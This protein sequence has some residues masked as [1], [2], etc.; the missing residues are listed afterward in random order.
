MTQRMPPHRWRRATGVLKLLKQRNLVQSA[1]LDQARL[2]D[3]KHLAHY[4]L[5]GV[6]GVSSMCMSVVKGVEVCAVV[7][8]EISGH[9]ASILANANKDEV[10]QTTSHPVPQQAIYNVGT[11]PSHNVHPA[12]AYTTT[13]NQSPPAT[14][15]FQGSISAYGQPAVHF[16]SSA[17]M[18]GAQLHHNAVHPSA[19]LS[20][21][22]HPTYSATYPAPVFGGHA[23]NASTMIGNPASNVA[24][25]A[26]AGGGFAGTSQPTTA[27]L[28]QGQQ[29]ASS[30]G[31]GRVSKFAKKAVTKTIEHVAG[32]VVGEAVAC[33]AGA[34]VGAVGP[35]V[36]DCL[37]NSFC[38]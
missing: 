33:G 25:Q 27:V 7:V 32:E 21:A 23:N 5:T 10:S 22:A 9:A 17:H 35:A 16:G 11:S 6:M 8:R 13:I 14:Q 3:H 12:Y 28:G 38:G 36:A 24:H 19:Y 29:A 4:C 26:V 37:V 15:A 30:S 2:A 1:A 18:G 31:C 34:V 20:H